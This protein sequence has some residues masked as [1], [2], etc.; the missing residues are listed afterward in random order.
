MR[1]NYERNSRNLLTI[2]YFECIQFVRANAIIARGS[3]AGLAFGPLFVADT[4]GSKNPEIGH[5]L[6]VA[7]QI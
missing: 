2:L 4:E 7:I 6:Q 1:L 5:L 3:S